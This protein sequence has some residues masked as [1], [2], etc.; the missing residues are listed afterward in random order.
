MLADNV[1]PCCAEPEITG[2]DTNEGATT[3]GAAAETTALAADVAVAEPAEFDAD[4]VVRNV[5]PTSVDTSEYD[6]P[7]GPVT[8]L[9]PP[10]SHR[11]H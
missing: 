10:E 6:C 11:Y 8:Q 5:F 1:C 9:F 2:A 7:V 3:L 4:T